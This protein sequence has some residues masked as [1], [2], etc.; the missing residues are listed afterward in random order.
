VG[1]IAL[2]PEAWRIPAWLVLV[3]S[4]QVPTLAQLLAARTVPP[5]PT[6]LSIVVEAATDVA[7]LTEQLRNLLKDLPVPLRGR[8]RLAIPNAGPTAGIAAQVAHRLQIP[9][10]APTG[11]W[12]PATDGRGYADDGIGN[13]AWRETGWTVY[14]PNSGPWFA[15]STRLQGIFTT[16]MRRV[17]GGMSS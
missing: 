14:P 17:P 2:P 5:D 13:H 1:T 7:V 15:L 11:S 6:Q 10:T 12:T 9:I 16:K 3:P 4:G 8:L